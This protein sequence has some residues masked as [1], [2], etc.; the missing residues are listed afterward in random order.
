MTDPVP[1]PSAEDS[2]DARTWG[3]LCHLT[4]LAGFVGVPFGHILGPL[5]CWLIKKNEYAFV[6]DQGKEALNFQITLT[7]VGIICLP[8]LLI[9]IGIP[10]LIAV[11]VLGVV[12]SIIGALKANDGVRYR[13]PFA[14]R[15]L[16]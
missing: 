6:E 16:K 11:A 7:I 12:F 13:Y 2:K 1:S 4:A 3:M 15:L 5:V 14:W 9:L 10:M 8:F